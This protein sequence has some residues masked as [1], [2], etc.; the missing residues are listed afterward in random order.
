MSLRHSRSTGPK[1]QS[2]LSLAAA[3]SLFALVAVLG[4]HDLVAAERD[5]PFISMAARPSETACA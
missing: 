1:A 2:K 3:A 5:G 4:A